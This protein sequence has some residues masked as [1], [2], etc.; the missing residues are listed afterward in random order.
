MTPKRIIF[1]LQ[2]RGFDVPPLRQLAN[3]IQA[4]R[5]KRQ[6]APPADHSQFDDWLTP[7][8][9]YEANDAVDYLVLNNPEPVGDQQCFATVG[10]PTFHSGEQAEAPRIVYRLVGATA[11]PASGKRVLA[12]AQ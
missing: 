6:Q 1:A 10:A 8:A 3:F 2:E 4:Y 5:K 12:S 9:R 7:P 11:P